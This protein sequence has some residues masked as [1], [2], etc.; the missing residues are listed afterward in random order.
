MLNADITVTPN[1]IPIEYTLIY[2]DGSGNQSSQISLNYDEKHKIKHF[3]VIFPAENYPTWNLIYNNNGATE[4][5]ISSEP[6]KRTWNDRWR[7]SG[8]TTDYGLN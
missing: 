8:T 5:F 6:I 2:E 1:F 7:K 4:Y 3:D